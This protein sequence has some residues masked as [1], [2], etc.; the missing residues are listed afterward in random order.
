MTSIQQAAEAAYP[1]MPHPSGTKDKPTLRGWQQPDRQQQAAFIA[2]HER[3]LERAEQIAADWNY[4]KSSEPICQD[5]SY[6]AAE[7][8]AA[9]IRSLSTTTTKEEK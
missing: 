6:T 8:I 5:C 9:A 7:Q 1:L 2:G 3:A 4:R